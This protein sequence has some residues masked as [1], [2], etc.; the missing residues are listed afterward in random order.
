MFNLKT[1][2]L[3]EKHDELINLYKEKTALLEK[4][5]NNLLLK[6]TITTFNVVKKL[7]LRNQTIFKTKRKQS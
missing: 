4:Y 6:I 7:W 1:I 2:M 5:E 3:I